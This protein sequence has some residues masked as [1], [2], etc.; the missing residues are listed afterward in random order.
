MSGRVHS[1]MHNSV[2][3]QDEQGRAKRGMNRTEAHGSRKKH[4]EIAWFFMK[5][6]RVRVRALWF[7]LRAKEL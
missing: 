3:E 7:A 4:G 1:D 5:Q 2:R 6:W